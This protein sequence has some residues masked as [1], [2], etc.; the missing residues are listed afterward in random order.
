MIGVENPQAEG[1]AHGTCG[2][3]DDFDKTKAL[4][5]LFTGDWDKVSRAMVEMRLAHVGIQKTIGSHFGLPG[6]SHTWGGA[7]FSLH[8]QFQTAV[9]LIW[10]RRFS[11]I[12]IGFHLTLL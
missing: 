8:A 1:A 10:D 9:F 7:G 4:F 3:G 5:Y 6:S 2:H 12:G 11:G